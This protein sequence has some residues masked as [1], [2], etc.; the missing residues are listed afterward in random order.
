MKDKALRKL[1]KSK[2][3]IH[4]ER[5]DCPLVWNWTTDN[6]VGALRDRVSALFVEN[7]KL[8]SETYTLTL[9]LHDFMLKLGK[10][11]RRIQDLEASIGITH[12]LAYSASEEVGSTQKDVK[13]LT[14]NLAELHAKFDAINKHYGISVEKQEAQ[15]VVKD[16][17]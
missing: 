4:S 2:G 15:Y 9:S 3:L 16:D 14:R 6:D 12:K 17:S 1:L 11:E 7:K 5:S 10:A 8:N 13:V